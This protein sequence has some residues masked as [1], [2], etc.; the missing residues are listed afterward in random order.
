M[1]DGRR[2]LVT[3]AGGFIGGRVVEVLHAL[4]R[5]AVVA[6]VRRFSSAARIGRLPVEIIRCDVTDAE[7]VRA[8]AQGATHIVHCAVGS[9]AAT[10]TGTRTVLDV[11]RAVGVQRVVHVSTIDVYGRES[12]VVTEDLPMQRTGAAYGDT[13]IAAEEACRDALANGLS[14]AIVRPT[15]VYGPFSALWTIEFAERLQQRPWPYPPEQASGTCNAVYVDDVVHGILRC[16]SHE[17][18]IGEAFNIN[19]A[20]WPSW[21]AYFE[22]LNAALA[23]PPIQAASAGASRLHALTIKPLRDSAKL[24]LRLFQPQIMALYQR[25]ALAKTAMKRVERIIRA[26]PTTGEFRLYSRTA[27]FPTDK[28]AR[29]IGYV[30]RFALDDGLRFSAQWLRH[31]GY[32]RAADAP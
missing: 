27:T 24:A 23:L 4:G 19:G 17:R 6:G 1:S 29:L 11:A 32:I 3:G 31:H 22:K 20:D 25:S 5:D 30:P 8:A 16:L 12:G 9:E 18:A 28:A 7:S 13:K 15:I 26:A 21:Y 10:V 2:I 14:V